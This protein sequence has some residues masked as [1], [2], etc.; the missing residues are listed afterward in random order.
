MFTHGPTMGTHGWKKTN[1]WVVTTAPTLGD[2][3]FG[4]DLLNKCLCCY[5][6]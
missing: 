5:I 4:L 1:G 2:N 3:V 6:W